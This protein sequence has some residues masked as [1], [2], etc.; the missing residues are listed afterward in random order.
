M[1]GEL[2][3]E[4]LAC[5]AS[6]LLAWLGALA[7]FLIIYPE[8]PAGRVERSVPVAVRP[9]SEDGSPPVLFVQEKQGV[10]ST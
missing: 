6:L 9:E 10:L 5:V 4:S 3:G 7:S 1:T 8:K 2:V